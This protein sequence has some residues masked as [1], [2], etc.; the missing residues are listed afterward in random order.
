MA[1]MPAL[2]DPPPPS[3]EE[4]YKNMDPIPG[5]R[6]ELLDGKIIMTGAPATG[7]N[8]VVYRLV[9]ALVDVADRNGWG[10]LQTE[11]IHIPP[12]RERPQPDLVIAPED[13]PEYD[14]HELYGHGVILVVEVVSPGSR[15]DDHDYK[16]GIYARGEVP[17]YLVIDPTADIPTATLHSD[18]TESGYTTAI[19]VPL[20]KP[21]TL[22]E[23]LDIT[24][25]TG[26]LLIRPRP[27][28]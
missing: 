14:D 16:A 6:V 19:R 18:P 11:A 10:L 24:L 25:D 9:R 12:T 22:P 8:W 27:R 7:H 5:V 20:G 26:V 2:A 15:H 3:I 13:A 17:R 21:L 28:Q 4:I 1:A 23:P